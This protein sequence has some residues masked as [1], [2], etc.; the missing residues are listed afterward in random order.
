MDEI[1]ELFGA[2]RNYDDWYDSLT[3]DEREWFHRVCE[4]ATKRGVRP[5]TAGFCQAFEKRFGR[6]VAGQTA[7]KHIRK[8]TGLA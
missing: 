2:S 4:A 5:S 6:P 3:P 7:R 8:H 1:D